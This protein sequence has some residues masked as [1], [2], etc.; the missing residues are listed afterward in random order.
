MVAMGQRHAD[1]RRR[2][3]AGGDAV[4]DLDLEAERAQVRDFLAAAAEHERIA[5]LEANDALAAHRLAAI[6]RSM[7]ACG[8]LAQ[9]PRL[10]TSTMRAEPRA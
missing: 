5:A 4:D 8:V 6:K 2:G 10:P 3:E 7:K 9:P 1:R